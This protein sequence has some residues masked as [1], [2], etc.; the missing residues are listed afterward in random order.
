MALVYDNRQNLQ[1]SAGIHALIAG[2]SRYTHLPGGGGPPAKKDWDHLPQLTAT[3]L[4]A[5]K[6]Y[7]WLIDHRDELPKPLATVRLLLSPTDAEAEKIAK[8]MSE[9]K[10]MLEG[11]GVTVNDKPSPC[12]LQAFGIEA[13]QWKEDAISATHDEHVTFFYFAGHGIQRKNNDPV[14]LMEDFGDPAWNNSVVKTVAFNAFFDGMVPLKDPQRKIARTQLYFIDACRVPLDDIGKYEFPGIADIFEKELGG[15]DNRSAPVFYATVSN[16]QAYSKTGEQT[17]FSEALIDSLNA[18]A[19]VPTDEQDT[20]G[21]ARYRVSI[22]SLA[23]KLNAKAEAL[24]VN[25]LDQEF[26]PNPKG[27]NETIVNFPKPPEVECTLYIDP[28]PAAQHVSVNVLDSMGDAVSGWSVSPVDPH[29]YHG[30]LRVGLYTLQA[31]ITKPPHPPYVNLLTRPFQVVPQKVFEL[32][33]R[34]IK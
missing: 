7:R 6:I 22:Y 3:A 4:T 25:G 5:Y 15:R 18:D 24:Q 2:V 29:P 11:K 16:T 1:G 14:L 9:I 27:S 32:K 19:V 33:A 13:G 23:E 21:Y 31:T 12:T 34:M 20:S 17:L 10:E 30:S 8:G 26:Y 28:E